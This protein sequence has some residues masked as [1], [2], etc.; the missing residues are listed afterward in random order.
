MDSSNS[1]TL[2]APGAGLPRGELLAARFFFSFFCR[3]S[4]PNIAVFSRGEMDLISAIYGGIDEERRKVRVLIPR[5]RGIE[6]SS[7][8]WSLGMTANH[9]VITTSAMIDIAE[10]LYSGRAYPRAVMIEDVKPDSHFSTDVLGRLQNAV[11]RLC[12]LVQS[13][14]DFKT[15]MTHRHPWFG[16][17]NSKQW[18]YL[19]A[20]HL[21][22]H[23]RQMDEIVTRLAHKY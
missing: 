8:N 14:K 15:V 10:V 4:A 18:L 13:G 22:I 12:A 16:P 17:F 7:R 19:A 23:R 1:Q 5:L 11:H 3:T 6:D 9:L 20:Y 2:E 21:R